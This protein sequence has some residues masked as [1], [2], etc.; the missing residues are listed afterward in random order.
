MSRAR[1]GVWARRAVWGA[2]A[3]VAAAGC[4]PLTTLAFLTHKDVKVPAEAPLTF[5]EGPKKG[6]EEVVVAVFVNQPAGQ[7]LEFPGADAMLAS[8]LARRLPEMSKESKQKVAV[9]PPK[10]VNKYKMRNP[11]WRTTEFSKRGKEL[12][13][14]FVLDINLDRMSLFQPGSQ[15][16]FYEGRA[17]VSVDVYDVDAG[18]GEPK[19]SRPLGVAYPKTGFRDASSMPVS[20]F[21]RLFLE[22]LAVEITRLHVDHRPSSGIADG[23]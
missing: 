12:G 11:N 1:S 17:D 13:A 5:A 4:N 9:V 18:P 16:S 21:R 20:A 22:N 23:R 6:K 14:D 15:N 7:G 10:D 19:H 8:E 3:V 2:F